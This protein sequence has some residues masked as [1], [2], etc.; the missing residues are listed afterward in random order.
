MAIEQIGTFYKGQ[1]TK[2]KEHDERKCLSIYQDPKT[3]PYQIILIRH[4]E[5]DINKKGW[6]SR[7]QAEQFAGAYDTV[8]VI[9]FDK[10]LHCFDGLTTGRVYHSSLPRSRHTAQLLFGGN[11]ELIENAKFREFERKVMKFINLKMPLMFWLGTSRI[12]WFMDMNDKD[13]ETFEE[14]KS[15]ARENAL[16]LAEEAK[17]DGQVILVAHGLLNR[18]LIKYLEKNGWEQVRNEGSGYLS[19]NI[20]AKVEETAIQNE[21]VK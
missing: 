11:L 15:R 20:L 19:V 17:K 9:P 16:F 3:K 5:P 18:Y 13:I 10:K 1:E 8:G 4:G 2:N 12:L 7:N 6:R 21:A 14:A